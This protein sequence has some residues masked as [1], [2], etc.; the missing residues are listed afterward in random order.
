MVNPI[1]R[2]K[3]LPRE[4]DLGEYHSEAGRLHADLHLKARLVGFAVVDAGTDWYEAHLT[5]STKKPVYQGEVEPFSVKIYNSSNDLFEIFSRLKKATRGIQELLAPP[6]DHN[7]D[8]RTDTDVI[9]C[10]SSLEDQTAHIHEERKLAEEKRRE[11][12]YGKREIETTHSGKL[13]RAPL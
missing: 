6:T 10:I 11:F 12:V 5:I 13:L 9:R 1:E 7:W 4:E 8:P 3:Q 2:M